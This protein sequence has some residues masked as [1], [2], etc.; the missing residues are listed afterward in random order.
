M[1]VPVI[2]VKGSACLTKTIPLACP[3]CRCCS[4]GLWS[5]FT[6]SHMDCQEKAGSSKSITWQYAAACPAELYRKVPWHCKRLRVKKSKRTKKKKS[7]ALIYTLF[8]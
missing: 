1:F 2:L 7:L 3:F 5:V 6:L 4:A 8:N